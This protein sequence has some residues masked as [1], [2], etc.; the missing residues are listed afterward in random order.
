METANKI[1]QF[2]VWL[3]T[4]VGLV[5]TI[6]GMVS[7]LNLALKHYVFPKAEEGYCVEPLPIP[8]GKTV[9]SNYLKNCR[10]QQDAQRQRDAASA[11]AEVIVGVPVLFGFYRKTK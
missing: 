7:V 11:L 10:D 1:K 8:D 6:I 2:F 3:F 5:L 4:L 9:D